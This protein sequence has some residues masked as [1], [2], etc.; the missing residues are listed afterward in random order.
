MEDPALMAEMLSRP[1]RHVDFILNCVD[2]RRLRKG[3][4]KLVFLLR[5]T[6]SAPAGRAASREAGAGVQRG[7]ANRSW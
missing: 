4:R 5:C 3:L 7:T 6:I 2:A 1:N